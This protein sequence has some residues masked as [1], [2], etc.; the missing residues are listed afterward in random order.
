[1][2]RP[3]RVSQ[4]WDL[5]GS[6]QQLLSAVFSDRVVSGWDT[7]SLLSKITAFAPMS[8][9]LDVFALFTWRGRLKQQFCFKRA[10]S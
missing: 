9:F 10:L 2:A 1:M 7:A 4:V 3:Q 5:G 8:W 6:G